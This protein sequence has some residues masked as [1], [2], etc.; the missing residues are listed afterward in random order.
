MSAVID[1]FSRRVVG[2]SMSASMTAQLVVD[3]LL[4]AV[5]RRGNPDTPVHHSDQDSQYTSKQFQRLMVDSSIVCSTGRSG[6]VLDN[7]YGSVFSSVKSERAARL[8]HQERG[9]GNCL[10]LYQAV[11]QCRPASFEDGCQLEVTVGSKLP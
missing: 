1:L 6:N 3:A 11:L 8:S 5:W 2:W 9:S 4:I 7:G 10:R